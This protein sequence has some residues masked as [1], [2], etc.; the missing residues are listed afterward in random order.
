MH[1]PIRK[2]QLKCSYSSADLDNLRQFNYHNSVVQKV[3]VVVWMM[4]VHHSLWHLKAW[5]SVGGPV[6]G[7]C[8]HAETC[9]TGGGL[10]DFRSHVSFPVSSLCFLCVILGVTLSS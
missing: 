3:T 1:T 10:W 8:G 5:C 2:M 9:V 6:W 4:N 7:R